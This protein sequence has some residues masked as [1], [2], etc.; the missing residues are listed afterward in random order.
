M[1]FVEDL[2]LLSRPQSAAWWSWIVLA[3]SASVFVWS[4][5][6]F[7][8]VSSQLEQSQFVVGKLEQKSRL[9]AQIGDGSSSLGY[10]ASRTNTA[11]T[12]KV[13]I[14]ASTVRDALHAAEALSHPWGVILEA[15]EHS[16][17]AT[18]DS[19]LLGVHHG[20]TQSDISI[21]A[22]VKNDAAALAL[23]DALSQRVDIFSQV[24]LHSRDALSA[25]QGPFTLHVQLLAQLT[26]PPRSDNANTTTPLRNFAGLSGGRLE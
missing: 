14:Q 18:Q 3:V 25:P 5:M 1:E 20:L 22:V 4:S 19:A 21:D 10:S 26:D 15:L 24:S 8:R 16:P 11:T 6:Y 23:V 13:R 7:N 9:S 12:E 2:D 17:D